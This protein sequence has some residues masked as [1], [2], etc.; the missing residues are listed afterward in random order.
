MAAAK[1][2]L[3]TIKQSSS[4]KST[5][6]LPLASAPT[7][8][9]TNEEG[10]ADPE[11]WSHANG[12]TKLASPRPS[13]LES[14]DPDTDLT[15]RTAGRRYVASPSECEKTLTRNGLREICNELNELQK[16]TLKRK[17]GRRTSLCV[18]ANRGAELHPLLMGSTRKFATSAPEARAR[19]ENP[20]LLSDSDGSDDSK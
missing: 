10:W 20:I 2:P 16:L 18:L 11:Q 5:A 3:I 19:E 17:E 6:N 1:A 14:R 4:T 12:Y 9:D 13:A 15:T 7:G 8:A